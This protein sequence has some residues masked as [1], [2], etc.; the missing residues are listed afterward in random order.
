MWSKRMSNPNQ[1]TAATP[2]T[3]RRELIELAG[4]YSLILV[5]IWT[6]RPLQWYLWIV[7]AVALFAAIAT[8]FDG[9]ETMGLC[10]ANLV[11]SLWGIALALVVAFV[12]VELADRMHTLNLPSTPGLFLQHYGAY[13]VWAAI[14]QVI[15]Q[16]FILSRSMRLLPNATA[17]A[18]VSAALFAIAHLPNPVLTVITLICG[19]ASCLFFVCYRHLWPLVVA[20]AILDRNT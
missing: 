10:R 17:A 13:A 11:Q 6:P 4:I 8:S 19:L 12:A 16:C 7:A 2:R 9:L 5:V 14:Q 1:C 18:A 15:L 20:H 3:R